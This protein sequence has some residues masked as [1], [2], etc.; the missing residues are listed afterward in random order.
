MSEPIVFGAAYS[1]YV[2]AVRL[3]LE[4][5]GVPYQLVDIDVFAEGG[6]P[7]D[8]MAR[9]PFGRIPAF[10]HDG[11]QLYETDAINRY[12]DET[13]AGPALTPRT[14]RARARMT[15]AMRILDNY[16]Y[17]HLVWGVFVE[18]IRAPQQGR[19]PDQMKIEAAIAQ[20]QICLRALAELMETEHYLTGDAL[21]LADLHAAPMFAYFQMAP[22]GRRLMDAQPKL[23][24]WWRSIS[25][26]PSMAATRSPLEENSH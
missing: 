13:F 21:T 11:F 19:A 9:H 25:Q 23:T 6:P 10:E 4:E 12:I 8:Y 5:K 16:A 14:P 7:P 26:R 17:P 1:V 22:D 24:Q 3:T 20:S 2:R 18:Q 15:Q